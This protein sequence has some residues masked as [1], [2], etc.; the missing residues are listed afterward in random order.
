MGQVDGGGLA[1][2]VRGRIDSEVFHH[3]EDLVE[4]G[5]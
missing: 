1:G 5:I 4:A 2:L 3:F